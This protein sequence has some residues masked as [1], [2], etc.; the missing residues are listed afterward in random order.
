[1][2]RKDEDRLEIDFFLEPADNLV[3]ETSSW[4]KAS[5]WGGC[6]SCALVV[7]ATAFVSVLFID[8][9]TPNRLLA[10]LGLLLL[11]VGLAAVLHLARRPMIESFESTAILVV[12]DRD[13]VSNTTA[14]VDQFCKWSGVSIIRALDYGLA[15]RAI[16][17]QFYVPA[18]V[19]ADRSEIENIVEWLQ[20]MKTRFG[21]RHPGDSATLVVRRKP[22]PPTES[23]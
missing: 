21:V 18:R 20:Q 5:Y 14:Y 8:A 16:G 19:F 2:I 22:D 6:R 7:A 11:A 13:G 4:R 12:A 9:T 15:V 3:A 1:L 10:M 23:L 17:F